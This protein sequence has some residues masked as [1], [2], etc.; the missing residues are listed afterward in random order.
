VVLAGSTANDGTESVRLP[1]VSAR[2]ARIQVQALGA[3]FFD[4]SHANLRIDFQPH[5]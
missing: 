1:N 5:G 4:V 3:P 2:R